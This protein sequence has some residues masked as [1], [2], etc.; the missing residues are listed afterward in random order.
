[1][2]TVLNENKEG[3][4]NQSALWYI[5][6]EISLTSAVRTKAIT[7][8]GGSFLMDTRI[9]VTTTIVPG[10]M[11]VDVG[12]GTNTDVF[13]DGWDGSTGSIAANT[14]NAFGRG[15]GATETGVK[16][17]LFFQET[18]TVDVKVNTVATSGKIKLMALILKSPIVQNILNK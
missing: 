17:G 9:L 5:S 3:Q 12:I 6:D 11:D 7:V 8:S 15:S 10:S 4:V 1:M 18:D 16:V 13:V 14:L 2:Q